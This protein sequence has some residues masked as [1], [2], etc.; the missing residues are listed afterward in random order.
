MSLQLFSKS[1]YI[2]LQYKEHLT[3]LKLTDDILLSYLVSL[4]PLTISELENKIEEKLNKLNLLKSDIKKI[5]FTC[6]ELIQN[7]FLYGN[8]DDGYAENTY[9]II[10]KNANRIKVITANPIHVSLVNSLENKI[11]TINSFNDKEELKAY[12][13]NHL[14][15]NKFGEKGGAG[16]GLISLALKSNNLLQNQFKQIDDEYSLFLLNINF[17]VKLNDAIV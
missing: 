4:N 6:I 1:S 3:Q 16:L 11:A 13:L 12:Y 10:S 8:S 9:F 5:F 2:H 17:D 7:Q 14:V 15:N